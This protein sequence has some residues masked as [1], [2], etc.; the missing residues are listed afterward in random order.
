MSGRRIDGSEIFNPGLLRHQI[1]WQQKTVSG[2]NSAGE[3]IFAWSTFRTCRVE[4]KSTT[5]QEFERVMQIWPEADYVVQQN[6]LLG[7]LPDMRG[8]WFVDGAVIYL[9]I[10]DISDPINNR[11]YQ[12]IVC[13][14]FVQGGFTA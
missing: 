10:L 6:F 12:E 4:I 8:S 3:D 9:D 7:M 5:G 1:T 13:R 14:T 2:Q 11:A